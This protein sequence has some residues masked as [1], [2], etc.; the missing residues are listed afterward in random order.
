MSGLTTKQRAALW[1]LAT[2]STSA[3]KNPYSSETG[4]KVIDAREAAK[5][6][7][8]SGTSTTTPTGDDSFAQEVLNQL[9]GR[10]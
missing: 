8:A 4:Q 1:Q 7:D 5:E 3:R 10:G 9:L 2:G 6:R